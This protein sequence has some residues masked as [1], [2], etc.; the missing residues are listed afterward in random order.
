MQQMNVAIVNPVF[1]PPSSARRCWPARP[2]P[3]PAR[4]PPLGDRRDRC[5]PSAPSSI[6]VAGNIPLNDALDAAGPVDKIKDL[7]AVRADFE[8]LW[9]KLEH[10][11]DLTSAG[12][13]GLPR[14]WRHSRR[15]ADV[16]SRRPP[17]ASARSAT[18][19][20][21]VRAS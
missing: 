15:G 6:T 14:L 9:V 8:S 21:S 16:S 10:R 5:S 3:W 4:T 17:R 7:A 12:V 2:S 19:C 1:M 18:A 11:A 13:A 20:S